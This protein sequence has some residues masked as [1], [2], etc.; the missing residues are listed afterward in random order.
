VKFAKKIEL[1]PVQNPALKICYLL[2]SE[3]RKEKEMGAKSE[4]SLRKATNQK[5][6]RNTKSANQRHM[7]ES[8]HFLPEY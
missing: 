4:L 8:G 3:C 5:P 6:P 1:F 7:Y 2:R